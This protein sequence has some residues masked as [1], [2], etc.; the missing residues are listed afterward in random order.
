[1]KIF[2]A[3]G[4]TNKQ[5]LTSQSSIEHVIRHLQKLHTSLNA[6]HFT[7]ESFE[8]QA[9]YC[10]DAKIHYESF[11]NNFHELHTGLYELNSEQYE[12][13]IKNRDGVES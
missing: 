1:M 10:N 12:E 7:C 4:R 6:K 8:S 11:L 2:T 9:D 5:R 3:T 13:Y